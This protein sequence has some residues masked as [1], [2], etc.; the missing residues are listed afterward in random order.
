[1]VNVD[2]VERALN[3]LGPRAASKAPRLMELFTAKNE[4]EGAILARKLQ[5]RDMRQQLRSTRGQISLILR[6]RAAAGHS[7]GNG[8]SKPRK[9]PK[10]DVTL[11]EACV[12]ALKAMKKPASVGEVRDYVLKKGF[13]TSAKSDASFWRA[14]YGRLA[15]SDRVERVTG[16]NTFQLK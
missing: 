4:L 2:V 9:R 15:T 7:N 11:E 3:V 8:H 1:M 10:N 14:V 13:K 6:G 5:L 12:R 16:T